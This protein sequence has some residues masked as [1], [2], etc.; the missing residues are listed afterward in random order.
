MQGGATPLLLTI[1]K[2]NEEAIK[3]LSDQKNAWFLPVGQSVQVV[4]TRAVEL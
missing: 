2:R 3:R 4:V 1:Q